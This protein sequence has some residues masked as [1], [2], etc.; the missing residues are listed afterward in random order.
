MPKEA[1]V[2]DVADPYAAS[3][4]WSRRF[5]GLKLFLSLA[6]AGWEGYEQVIRRQTGMGYYLCDRLPSAGW[7]IMNRTP[8][9]LVC[10]VDGTHPKGRSGEY[11]SA[12]ANEI[13]SSGKAWISVTRIKERIPVLRACITN[14]RTGLEDI[15]ALV[16]DLEWARRRVR[17]R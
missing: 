6:V 7:D 17:N 16:D 1:E 4:Q 3:L 10:F 8:L 15:D 14:Y 5:I 11:L 9:P 13:V 12:V 2:L